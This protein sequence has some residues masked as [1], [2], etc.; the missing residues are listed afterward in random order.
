VKEILMMKGA[1]ILAEKCAA[2]KPGERV[3]IAT[4]FA[5][6]QMAGVLASAVVSLGAEPAVLSILPRSVDGEQLPEAA[7]AAMLQADVIFNLLSR[8]AAHTVAVKSALQ[9]G[10]RVVSLTGLNEERLAGGGIEADFDALQPLCR[11]VGTLLEGAEV[12]RVTTPQGTD[13]TMSLA[14]RKANVHGGLA[15]QPGQF[16]A[17][18]G[19]ECSISPVEGTAE[20]TFVFDASVPYLGI[21]VLQQPI[22]MRVEGGRVVEIS[23]GA[24]AQKLARMMAAQNDPNVY[25]IAQLSFGLNPLCHIQGSVLDDEGAYGTCHIG[26]GTSSNL[27]GEIRAKMHFDALMY[28]PTLEL[29]GEVVLRDGEWLLP[30]ADVVETMPR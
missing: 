1:L 4:D 3:L 22:T 12:A 29:D 25:N 27:G 30:E 7:G 18:Y 20:G 8:S 21:G 17:G 5:M 26:I 13:A 28:H 11:R 14:G 23:G 10:A 19:A 2:V 15:R 6:P 16:T 24:Q 9:N